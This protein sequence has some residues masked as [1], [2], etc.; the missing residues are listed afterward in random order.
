[1]STTPGWYDDGTGTMRWFDGQRW[2]DQVQPP[3]PGPGGISGA[4]AKIEA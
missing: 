2:T 1:M 4:I 3:P